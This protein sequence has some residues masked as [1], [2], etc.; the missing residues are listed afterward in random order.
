MEPVG[1]GGDAGGSCT[2]LHL[3]KQLCKSWR[4]TLTMQKP[5]LLPCTCKCSL[6]W[7][8][9]EAEACTT[10]QELSLPEGACLAEGLC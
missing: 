10:E 6:H 7:P 8:L 2:T 1:W 4:S 3:A 5:K 9:R